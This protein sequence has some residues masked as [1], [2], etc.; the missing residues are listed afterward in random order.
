MWEFPINKFVGCGQYASC[1]AFDC[2][3]VVVGRAQSNSFS[4]PLIFVYSRPKLEKVLSL[5]GHKKG[6]TCIA[7]GEE[8]IVSGSCDHSV[9]VWGREEGEQLAVIERHR[10]IVTGEKLEFLLLSSNF[11]FQTKVNK[12]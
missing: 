11:I 12:T 7:L 10:D 5:Y 1:F 9:R 8:I 6:V 4:T 2:K 3:L